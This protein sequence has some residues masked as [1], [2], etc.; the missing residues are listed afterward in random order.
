MMEFGE[1]LKQARQNKGFTQQTMADKLYVTRQAVSRWECGARYPDLLTAKKISQI[2]DTSI[3]ELLSEEELR[4]NIE[5]EPLL[6]RSAEN[7][8]QTCLYTVAAVAYMLLSIFSAYS[9]LFSDKMFAHTPA[10]RISPIEIMAILERVIS[11]VVLL[12]G[13][14]LSARNKLSA[15]MTGYIMWLPYVLAA[16]SFLVTYINMQVNQNGFMGI[17]GWVTDFLVPL[18]MAVYILLYFQLEERRLS[19]AV[20]C[21]ICLLSAGY[22]VLVLRNVSVRMTA[23]GF[24]AM[25]V[26]SMGKIGMIILLNYQAYIWD[27][28]KKTAYRKGG[29]AAKKHFT[30]M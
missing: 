22:I 1:K 2:L 18:A 8:V 24:V 23:L 26:H 5:K 6:A 4:E 10:G 16:V 28:K 12:A 7:I 25:S 19:Y 21:V 13:L 27:K 17:A 9:V 14:I 29:K 30:T 3:D 11:F 15:K 20:I